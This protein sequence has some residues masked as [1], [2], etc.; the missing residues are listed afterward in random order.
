MAIKA[1]SK[2]ARSAKERGSAAIDPRYIVPG[3]SRGLSLLQLFTRQKPSQTLADL[4]AGLG[5]SRS[6]AYRLVYT[7]EKEGFIARE[8]SGRNYRLTSEVLTLGFD[9]L[10]ARGLPEL[11]EPALRKLS[12]TT[13]AAAYVV[14]L[15]GW[16]AVYLARVMPSVALITNLQVGARLPVH[17]TAS[18]RVFLSH[19]SEERLRETYNLLKEH[20]HSVAPP[21]SF[22]Q[23][24]EQSAHDRA[25][26]YVYHRSVLNPGVVSLAYPVR[27]KAGTVVAAITVIGP[28][29]LVVAFGGEK[30]LKPLVAEAAQG[31]SQK[32]GY[33]GR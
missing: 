9:Y 31:M 20:C 3:L 32:L 15:D 16:H 25:R 10:N 8:P 4:A 29:Q 24:Q 2:T 7:L 19:Q 18:G 23:L 12:D 28:E 5:L 21:A 1:E 13:P 27:N 33:G 22:A 11:A 26:G 17:V 14:S 30:A 6:A